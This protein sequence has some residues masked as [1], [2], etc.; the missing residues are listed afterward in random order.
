M[1]TLSIS[2]LLFVMIFAGCKKDA[3]SEKGLYDSMHFVRQGSGQIDFKLLT[4]DDST[5]LKVVVSKVD[6]SDTTLEFLI[7]SN[8]DNSSAFSAFR[9]A[10]NN[11]VQLTGDF[12]QSTLPTGTWSSIYFVA[13]AKETETT[14]AELRDSL[15]KFEQ[16]VRDNIQ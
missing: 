10:I 7:V 15:L 8:T 1:K 2:L 9:K 6:F 4:T 13:N 5:K 12:Q 14:N 11:Q 16:I 3:G